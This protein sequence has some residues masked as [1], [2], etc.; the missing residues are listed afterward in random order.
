MFIRVTW[1]PVHY[2]K[3]SADILSDVISVSQQATG[4][5]A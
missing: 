2:L 3:D 5:D 4:L 1:K